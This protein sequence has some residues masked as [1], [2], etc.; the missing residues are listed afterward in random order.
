[1]SRARPTSSNTCV[2]SDNSKQQVKRNEGKHLRA[3]QPVPPQFPDDAHRRPPPTVVSHRKHSP[4][5]VSHRSNTH[6]LPVPTHEN[7]QSPKVL[8]PTGES[9]MR[10]SSVGESSMSPANRQRDSRISC[11]VQT[12]GSTVPRPDIGR[13]PPDHPST[14]PLGKVSNNI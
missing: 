9:L 5:S 10:P 3:A 7:R 2:T 13:A 8:L 4:A 6:M 11:Q 14:T 12:S 1:M